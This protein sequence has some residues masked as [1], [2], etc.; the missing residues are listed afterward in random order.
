MSARVASY[1]PYREEVQPIDKGQSGKHKWHTPPPCP[2]QTTSVDAKSD[3]PRQPLFVLQTN[4]SPAGGRVQTT[5]QECR[6]DHLSNRRSPE[7]Q[8]PSRHLTASLVVVNLGPC[9]LFVP[10]KCLQYCL[11]VA[12]GRHESRYIIDI[13]R[14]P[15]SI[16]SRNGDST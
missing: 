11:N 1:S 2:S 12:A 10:I 5:L 15:G 14:N 4:F 13:H 6:Q 3:R 16:P 7:D 9:P 8:P